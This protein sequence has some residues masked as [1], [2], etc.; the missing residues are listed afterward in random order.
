[1]RS[2][3]GGMAALFAIKPQ[4]QTENC[5]HAKPADD[6]T[7]E[8]F[9]GCDRVEFHG[10]LFRFLPGSRDGVFPLAAS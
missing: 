2:H 7:I 1:M 4:H 3:T 9:E 5:S 6:I 8:P 10:S